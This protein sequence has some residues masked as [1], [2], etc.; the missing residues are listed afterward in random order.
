VSAPPE[1]RSFAGSF[2]DRIERALRSRHSEGI[3]AAALGV[4]VLVY[5]VL[6]AV[7]VRDSTFTA[8]ELVWLLDANEGFAPADILAPHNG[9]L[10]AVT[11]LLFAGSLETVGLDHWPISA[12]TVLN[13]AATAIL[14]FVWLRGRIGGFGALLPA[15]VILFLGSTPVVLSPDVAVFA[16]STALGLAALLLLDRGDHLGDA[17]ACLA[18]L[19]GVASFSLG[20]PFA[21]GAAVLI[22]SRPGGLRRAWVV[23]VPLAAYGAWFVWA[24]KF[25][26]P[27]GDVENLL[28][29]PAFAADSLAAGLAAVVGL[30]RE[31]DG[32]PESIGLGWGRVLAILFAGLV[33]WRAMR[34]GLS[35]R[36]WALIAVLLVY[37]TLGTL[38]LTELLRAPETDRYAFPTA[39]LVVLLCGE[40]FPARSRL[41]DPR[42]AVAVV[43]AFVLAIGANLY[44]MRDAGSAIRARSD[45][46]RVALAML[47]LERD[48]VD[49][50]FAG[51]VGLLVPVEAGGY[52]DLVDRHGSIAFSLD[53]VASGSPS[54]RER[55][56][57]ALARI[58][59]P[60]LAD[61]GR[62]KQGCSIPILPEGD[63]FELPPSGAWISSPAAV[64]VTLRRFA[65]LPTVAAGTVPAGRV[66]ELQLPRD[67]EAPPWRVT[68]S[69]S[70]PVEICAEAPGND[71]AQRRRTSSAT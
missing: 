24:S 18:L 53:E 32:P 65:D 12:F 69:G 27:S 57:A 29:L 1:T 55:A 14:A 23:L 63:E 22:G 47:E 70:A 43:L 62:R 44:E 11:R 28:Q 54:L 3:A 9:H 17:G 60:G 4:A 5:A 19:A 50:S 59:A 38:G 8:D 41:A 48:H 33:V 15:V 30:G 64:E 20:I 66:G 31:L 21:V 58:L 40:L 26:Q 6:A 16:Q 49:P 25:D 52:L 34:G 39:V 13:V 36:A 35:G 37:W 56:D 51:S 68:V 46:T 71:A 2:L 42:V 61:A 45:Q 10:I 67:P 7:L